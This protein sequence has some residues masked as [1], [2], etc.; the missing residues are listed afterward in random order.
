MELAEDFQN[1]Q[2]GLVYDNLMQKQLYE[3][4][5]IMRHF[6]FEELLEFDVDACADLLS[7]LV[8][9]APTDR[10]RVLDALRRVGLD[11]ELQSGR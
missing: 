11:K 7:R 10:Q 8:Y 1:D 2:I 6:C 5:S 9:A 4:G 3:S